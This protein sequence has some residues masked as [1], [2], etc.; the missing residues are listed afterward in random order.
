MSLTRSMLRFF[1]VVEAGRG[2]PVKPRETPLGR[3]GV[4]LKKQICCPS[5]QIQN[6]LISSANQSDSGLRPDS[7]VCMWCD[8]EHLGE[9]AEQ[10][11][12]C[13]DKAFT[14]GAGAIKG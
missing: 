11:G 14:K 5:F 4:R 2:P 13:G 12:A 10:S 8:A 7:I 9:G 3:Y 6:P 1:E